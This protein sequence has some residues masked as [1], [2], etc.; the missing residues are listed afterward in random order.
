MRAVFIAVLV[1]G[2][3]SSALR[4][5]TL[6]GEAIREAFTGSTVAGRYVN[7]NSFSEYHSKDGRALGDNGFALNVDACWNIDADRVCYHYGPYKDRRTFCFT[8]ER[9]GETYHLKVADSGRLNAIATIDRGNPRGHG[10][11]GRRWSCDDLLSRAVLPAK[12]Q[13]LALGGKRGSIDPLH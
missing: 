2:A 5:E 8:V 13:R 1:L 4:A 12:R 10:D 6:N 7:G 11:G 3:S 9:F